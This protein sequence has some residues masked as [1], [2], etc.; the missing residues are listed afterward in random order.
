MAFSNKTASILLFS[1]HLSLNFVPSSPIS[2]TFY[3]KNM[4][5]ER[6]NKN[7]YVAAGEKP[8]PQSH[9]KKSPTF[10]LPGFQTALRHTER[11]ELLQPSKNTTPS[12]L[13]SANWM[14]NSKLNSQK[15]TES[16]VFGRGKF[17][18]SK[19]TFFKNCFVCVFWSLS[20]FY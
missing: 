19:K 17:L 14:S 5:K 10:K 2:W 15:K 3:K 9:P 11:F 7:P 16:W 4:K 12:P 13:F 1:R 8:T 20:H 6:T 18:L